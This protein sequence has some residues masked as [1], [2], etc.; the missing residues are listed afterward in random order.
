MRGGVRKQ[1][2]AGRW[3]PS[4]SP[5]H[6]RLVFVRGR[7]VVQALPAALVYCPRPEST[8][9]R[10]S[11]SGTDC[12]RARL[13]TRV[14]LPPREGRGSQASSLGSSQSAPLPQIR[15]RPRPRPGPARCTPSPF[16]QPGPPRSPALTA[17]AACL[18]RCLAGRP[19]AAAGA[20]CP[21]QAAAAAAS[22]HERGA[23]EEGE[24]R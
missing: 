8:P 7:E 15:P 14:W 21:S 12:P 2:S 3:F 20:G 9:A 13:G 6:T 16:C 11:L 5:T 1:D 4:P 10:Q 18:P 19:A 22:E 17:A 24:R 23:G